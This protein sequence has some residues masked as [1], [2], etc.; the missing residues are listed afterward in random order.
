MNVLKF[1]PLDGEK[2]AVKVTVLSPGETAIVVPRFPE[3]F[4]NVAPAA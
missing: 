1:P 2:A 4:V 3:I